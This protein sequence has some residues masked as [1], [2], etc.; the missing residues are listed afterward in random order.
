MDKAQKKQGNPRSTSRAWEKAMKKQQSGFTLIELTVVVAIVFVLAAIAMPMYSD[1]MI[2]VQVAE[3]IYLA[4][5]IRTAIMDE[6]N[7]EGTLP[8]NNNQGNLDN[9]NEIES[10]FVKSIALNR[11]RIEIQ[12]GNDA[13]RAIWGKKIQLEPVIVG[14]VFQWKCVTTGGGVDDKYLPTDFCN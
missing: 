1:Y 13:N 3:G 11:H 6:Y 2:R 7:T 10:R 9:Q 8:N 14:N 12:Y 5:P 4:A